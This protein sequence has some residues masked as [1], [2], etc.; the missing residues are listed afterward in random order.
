MKIVQVMA[1]QGEGGLEKHLTELSLSLSQT[2]EVHVIAD[3]K[4]EHH[5][6]QTKVIF[7]SIDFSKSR[8]NP[9]LLY[10]LFSMLKQ[11]NPDII[12]A[13]ANKA[14]SM[15]CTLK[16]FLPSKIIS[17]LHNYKK[18]LSDF[19]KSDFVITVSDKIGQN[20]KIPHKATVY[21]GIRLPVCSSID[22]YEKFQL[23]KNKFLLCSVGRFVKAK[24]FEILLKAFSLINSELFH[25]IL[26]GS[27]PDEAA[28]KSYARAIGIGEKITFT[29]ALYKDDVLAIMQ[30]SQLFV[31]TSQREG[32]P[33]TFVE[34]VLSQTPFL[35]TPVSDIPKFISN[36]Y[37][38]PFN[39]AL[40]TAKK[41]EWIFTNYTDVKKDFEAIYENVKNEFLIDTMVAKTKHIYHTVLHSKS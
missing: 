14:A 18:N 17:T 35:S 30:Q 39:D 38:V 15:I 9:F 31:M 32:F 36:S 26:V 12:H 1:S 22:I 28:L 3:T 34:T 33:Y 10:R 6:Q 20:L 11:L 41:I 29:G 4:Y 40:T 16:R 5:Y 7:H 21:N 27:G 37:I 25:L 24:R 23:P 19:E 13:Q 8:W 2:D